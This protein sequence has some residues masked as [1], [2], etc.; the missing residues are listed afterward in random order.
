[1][2]IRGWDFI[3]LLLENFMPGNGVL[4]ILYRRPHHVNMPGLASC[5]LKDT[6]PSH[7]CHPADSKPIL[8]SRTIGK[9]DCL[10]AHE[11][12]QLRLE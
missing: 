1:M 2:V 12:V 8:Q 5:G 7:P 11:G 6:C 10:Q 4:T 9:I 3:F